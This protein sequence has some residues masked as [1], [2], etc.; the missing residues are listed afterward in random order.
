MRSNPNKRLL[1]LKHIICQDDL[2]IPGMIVL[3]I[4]LH[5]NGTTINNMEGID[6]VVEAQR[7]GRI[8]QFPM[9]NFSFIKILA[10]L[11]KS[12]VLASR[13]LRCVCYV[14]TYMS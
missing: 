8:D 12:A 14:L 13:L 11:L 3:R 7:Y 9:R 10:C 1:Q 2:L 5:R 6:H 4:K